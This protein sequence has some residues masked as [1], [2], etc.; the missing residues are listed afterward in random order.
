MAPIPPTTSGALPSLHLFAHHKLHATAPGLTLMHLYHSRGPARY[1]AMFTL[2]WLTGCLD[3]FSLFSLSHELHQP[4][5]FYLVLLLLI[6][7]MGKSAQLGL[8]VWLPNAMEGPTPVSALIHA[9]TMVT[10]GVYLVLRLH[11]VYLQSPVAL[12]V[13]AL[14]GAVT[15]VFAAAS[16]LAEPDLKRVLAYS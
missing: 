14:V 4:L 7:A 6:G 3:Y 1:L 11:A 13:V 5:V 15:A 2:F 12:D 9:A 10:A 8:H 16:A